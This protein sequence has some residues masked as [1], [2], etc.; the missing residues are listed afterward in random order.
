[1]KMIFYKC[2]DSRINSAEVAL[3]LLRDLV[4]R[5]SPCATRYLEHLCYGR[6]MGS[7]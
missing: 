5:T 4:A 7:D 6:G 1:M 2:T 3:N